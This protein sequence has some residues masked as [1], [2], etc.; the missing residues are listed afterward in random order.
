[1]TDA[2]KTTSRT[3]P[4]MSTN[5]SLQCPIIVGRDD[6]LDL[7]ERRLNETAGGRGQ[8]LLLAGEAGIGKTRLLDAIRRKARVAGFIGA[9][10]AVAP[11]DHEVPSALILDLARTVRRMPE[12][13]DLGNDLLA[14]GGAREADVARAERLIST[15]VL[16]FAVSE[17]TGR[18]RQHDQSV[19]DA[20]FAELLRWLR[21]A[22]S[23]TGEPR[24]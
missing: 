22:L 21:R 12:F 13:G 8:F 14:M 2:S 20:D 9:N 16:G 6:L 3:L 5:G 7:A 10:G 4:L 17:A 18:F 1:M 11:Q 15:A 23:S 19:I 24:T